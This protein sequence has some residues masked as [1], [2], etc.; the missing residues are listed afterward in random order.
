MNASLPCKLPV[1]ICWQSAL[2]LLCPPRQRDPKWLEACANTY[3]PT[4]PTH[5]PPLKRTK[6]N[7]Q[8]SNLTLL[9][10]WKLPRTEG[11]EASNTPIILLSAKCL[12]AVLYIHDRSLRVLLSGINVANTHILPSIQIILRSYLFFEP[13]SKTIV[14]VSLLF[15]LWINKSFSFLAN[16]I[17]SSRICHIE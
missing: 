2:D 11:F 15:P 5:S 4:H 8:I 16:F 17:F 9:H 6:L 13:Y 7:T 14:N 3:I 12:A 10:F 1:L